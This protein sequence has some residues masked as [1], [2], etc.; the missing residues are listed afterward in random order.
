MF[1]G[2]F[3]QFGI[4]RN[5]VF[6]IKMGEACN[7]GTLRHVDLSYNS[8]D[9]NECEKFG[10]I[11]HD[12]HTLWGLHMMGNSCLLDSMGFIRLQIKTTNQSRDILHEQIKDGINFLATIRK[13]RDAKIKSY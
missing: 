9:Q 10:E 5:G 3:N 11:I 2:S 12:N 7:N 1:D 8:M 13:S 4:K 6:G